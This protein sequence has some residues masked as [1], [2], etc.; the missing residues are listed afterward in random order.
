MVSVTPLFVPG[1]RPERFA[2]VLAS[3]ADAMIIDL[4]DAVAPE[5]KVLAREG[6][7]AALP[8]MDIFV[9]INGVGTKWH[10]A[11]LAACAGA[12]ISAVMLAKT[13]SAA[14]VAAVATAT[15]R[16]VVALIESALGLAMAR[17]IA[18]NPGTLRL[19]FGSIDFCTDLG[20]AHTRDALLAARSALVLASRLAN[21]PPPLDGV[22]TSIHDSALIQDDA[23]YAQN[24]GFGG[25]LCIHPSQIA[26]VRAGFAPSD[27]DIAWAEKILGAAEHGAVSVDGAMVDAPVRLRAR[28]ILARAAGPPR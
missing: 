25:K 17:E 9:R 14:D 22:T 27:A 8:E 24:L 7:R 6:L 21:L 23:A 15:G 26:A 2:K 13:E 19:A 1:D 28:Q 16:K 11:D 10:A 5:N 12:K 20:A 18:G 4:E 3:G